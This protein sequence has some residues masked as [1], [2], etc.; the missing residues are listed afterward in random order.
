MKYAI[1][2]LILAILVVV[3]LG[4]L[5]WPTLHHLALHGVP[6][7]GVVVELLPDIHDTVRYRYKV[8]GQT[9]EGQRSSWPPNPPSEKLHVGQQVV[10]YFDPH[11]PEKS[12]LGEPKPM[13][14]NE[15]ISIALSAIMVPSFIVVVW[16]WRTSR[17]RRDS[18]SKT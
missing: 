3:G 9:F 6:A 1:T 13:L 4:S 17:R 11:Q 12:V 18:T 16:A 8:K 5:N 7:T 15:C 2:W 10:I 14:D